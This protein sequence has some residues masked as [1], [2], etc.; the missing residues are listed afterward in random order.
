MLIKIILTTLIST[1]LLSANDDTLKEAIEF[2]D[3][4]NI[5]DS[6][7]ASS[8]ASVAIPERKASSYTADELM[9]ALDNATTYAFSPAKAVST[10]HSSSSSSSDLTSQEKNK[11]LQPDKDASIAHSSSSSSSDLTSQ[12]KYKPPQKD[13]CFDVIRYIL[14]FYADGEIASKVDVLRITTILRISK[15]LNT[16]LFRKDDFLPFVHSIILYNCVEYLH[17]PY[18]DRGVFQDDEEVPL[19]FIKQMVYVFPKLK[20]LAFTGS[21]NNRQEVSNEMFN[22]IQKLTMLEELD[23]TNSLIDEGAL[24]LIQG[25]KEIKTLRLTSL[26]GGHPEFPDDFLRSF[27]KLTSLE[28]VIQNCGALSKN[29][30]KLTSLLI[31]GLGKS[32]DSD[33]D[34]DLPTLASIPHERLKT[35]S[36]DGSHFYGYYDYEEDYD[37][38]YDVDAA[39]K[40]GEMTRRARLQRLFSVLG[41]F[42]NLEEIRL[43]NFDFGRHEI[44][45]SPLNKLSQL[46]SFNC[47]K[48]EFTAQQISNICQNI[49]KPESL[50]ISGVLYYGDESISI[51]ESMTI[52]QLR[53]EYHNLF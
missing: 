41:T 25:N 17:D 10:A 31:E 42:K 12:K 18:E 36:I 50:S 13:L 5:C 45:F 1:A 11:P 51:N 24:K 38:N 30:I 23:L 2:C 19:N 3:L 47:R 8:H 53:S 34:E 6:A 40:A 27:P 15:K 49:V 21:D 33:D 44:D 52:T 43:T 28:T 32:E 20:K 22:E 4:K 16:Y 7:S 37:R 9:R 35:L 48:C 39:E 29:N 14:E 46:R 26:V